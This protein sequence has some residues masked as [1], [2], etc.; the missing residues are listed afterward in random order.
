MK[1]VPVGV[2]SGAKVSTNGHLGQHAVS[3][4]ET[5]MEGERTW[6]DT[7]AVERGLLGQLLS[8]TPGFLL[9]LLGFLGGPEAPAALL[10]HLRPRRNAVDGHEED[11]A[12]LY[13]GEEVIDVGEDGEDH[14]LLRQ[15]ERSIALRRRRVRAVVDDAVHVEAVG[16]VRE[17][18]RRD[19]TTQ[20]LLMV[21]TH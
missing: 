13:L 4:A 8:L 19:R 9:K 14:L 6:S 15:P 16:R 2:R 3:A 18:I 10:V 7:I 12:R 20:R 21:P 17:M 11:L 1:G 5:E